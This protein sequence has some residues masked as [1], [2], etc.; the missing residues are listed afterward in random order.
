MIS[1]N[2]TQDK[3]KENVSSHV[4]KKKQWYLLFFYL[5]FWTTITTNLHTSPATYNLNVCASVMYN[6]GTQ[7]D[8]KH[9]AHLATVRSRAET[10]A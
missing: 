10:K 3:L 5:T 9:A 8:R 7:Y 2:L 4:R 6:C 1:F